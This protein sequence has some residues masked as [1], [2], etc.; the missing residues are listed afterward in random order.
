VKLQT[1]AEEQLS[2]GK[3]TIAQAYQFFMGRGA[4]CVN[5]RSQANSLIPLLQRQLQAALHNCEIKVLRSRPSRLFLTSI[6][7]QSCSSSTKTAKIF[8][9][10]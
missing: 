2:L 3:A 6:R 10:R 5:A 9:R 1:A 8:E 4:H 7:T